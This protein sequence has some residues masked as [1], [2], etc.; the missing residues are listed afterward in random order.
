MI[1]SAK[2]LPNTRTHKYVNAALVS[3]LIALVVSVFQW[4]NLGVSTMGVFGI[5]LFCLSHGLVMTAAISLYTEQLNALIIQ[6]WLKV[7]LLFLLGALGAFLATLSSAYIF[8]ELSHEE[9]NE[10]LLLTQVSTNFS[11][12]ISV[13]AVVLLYE[14][15]RITYT[16]YFQKKEIEI[17]RIKQLKVREELETLQSKINPHFLYN[18]LNTIAGLVYTDPVLAEE[19]TLKLSKLFRYSI[20][21]SEALYASLAEELVMIQLFLDIEQIRW[22]NKL[23]VTISVADELLPL[24]FPRFLLQPLIENALKH[25]LD[26]SSGAGLIAIDIRKENDRLLISI[27]DNGKAFPQQ[28]CSGSGFYNTHEKLQ[29]LY[30]NVHEFKLIN[31]PV[32]HIRIVIPLYT[33]SGKQKNN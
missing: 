16:N 25:G 28:V 15:Q 30:P 6:R 5:V 18:S 33:T 7:P 1:I 13:S 20:N 11:I 31:Q 26:F 22:G 12:C 3:M 9:V 27:H 23:R 2:Y 8:S 24:S 14:S 10:H 4:L 19:L 32:K 29:L 21:Y 17:L